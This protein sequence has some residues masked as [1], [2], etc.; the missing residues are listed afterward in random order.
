L[1]DHSAEL[2]L[3]QF[4]VERFLVLEVEIYGAGRVLGRVVTLASETEPIFI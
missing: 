4:E 2:F 1:L 3:D